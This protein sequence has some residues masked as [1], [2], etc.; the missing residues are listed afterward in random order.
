MNILETKRVQELLAGLDPASRAYAESL[1]LAMDELGKQSL[2]AMILMVSQQVSYSQMTMSELTAALKAS[3]DASDVLRV[4]TAE[5]K[6]KQA[7][8]MQQVVLAIVFA[9][10]GGGEMGTL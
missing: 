7:M 10:L 2:D 4:K 5:L 6:Q 8:F 1:I 9:M 3:N